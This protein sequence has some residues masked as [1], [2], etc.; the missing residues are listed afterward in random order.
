MTETY[1][2]ALEKLC[3]IVGS[4][5]A[6]YRRL[7]ETTREGL[8]ALRTQ[9]VT[10]FDEILAEQVDTMR[11]LKDLE[12]ERERAMQEVGSPA[13]EGRLA[14]LSEELKRVVTDVVR[15]NRVSRL[16]IERNGALIEARLGLQGRLRDVPHAT[17]GVDETA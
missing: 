16:V 13:R 8:A 5:T 9:D 11:E 3:D 2:S 1:G 15:A 6:G 12:R 7:L 4:Q 17:V 14:E 10:R